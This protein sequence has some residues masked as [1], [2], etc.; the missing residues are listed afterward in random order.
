M[1][2]A[3]PVAC[4][5]EGDFGGTD[6]RSPIGWRTGAWD[7]VDWACSSAARAGCVGPSTQKAAID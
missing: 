2:D 4:D 1:E 6:S 5:A 7:R 3:E